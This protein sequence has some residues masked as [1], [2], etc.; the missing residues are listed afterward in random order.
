MTPPSTSSPIARTSAAEG[1]ALWCSHRGCSPAAS[2]AVRLLE[3]IVSI[4]SLSGREQE[5]AAC[6]AARMREAGLRARIDDAGNAVGEAGSTRTDAVQIVLLGHMDTVPGRVPV[7]LVGDELYGRGTVDAKG[8]L[9]A[10]VA[11]AASAVVPP[12]VRLIVVGAV[13]EECP[14]SRGAR[15]AAQQ[16]RPHACFIGEPSGVDGITL[17]YKGR[18]VAEVDISTGCSHSA[19]PEPTA[20]ELG[21]VWWRSIQDWA[22]QRN[23]RIDRVFDQVQARLRSIRTSSDGLTDT[24]RLSVSLRLP[25]GLDPETAASALREARCGSS[26]ASVNVRFEGREHAWLSDRS[27][28]LARSLSSAI[29][30]SGRRAHPRVKTGTSDMN[31]VGPV[32]NCPIVAYGPGDSSLDHTSDERISIPEFI[33]SISVLRRAIELAAAELAP[34]ANSD[35]RAG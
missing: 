18:L 24:A 22:A 20:A 32:W 21:T 25:P 5:V 1:V 11:A 10:F 12:N 19:G 17:G 27:N 30:E 13:E 8:P 7:R 14:T 29:R 28:V 31:V 23:Q 6:L 34:G 3:E 35:Q 9:A 16:Y 15:F 26:N 33:E 4:E 2:A